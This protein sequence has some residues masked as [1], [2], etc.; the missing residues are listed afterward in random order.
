MSAWLQKFNEWESNVKTSDREKQSISMLSAVCLDQVA[1]VKPR[2]KSTEL[3]PTK[4]QETVVIETTQQFLSFFS[5]IEKE[6]NQGQDAKF[7]DYLESVGEL[8]TLVERLIGEICSA[9]EI[10]EELEHNYEF[11]VKKTSGLQNACESLL[12]EQAHM[13]AISEEISQKLSYFHQLESISKLLNMP[14]DQLVLEPEFGPMLEKLDQCLAFVTDHPTF[15]DS[16]LYR[17]R[18][19]QCMTR[20]MTLIKLHFVDAIRQLQT[21]IRD[22]LK[23]QTGTELISSNVQLSLFFVKFR[24]L[25]SRMRGLVSELEMRC[26]S[27]QEYFAL[28]RDCI[29]AYVKVRR[30][31]LT[32][33]ISE[34]V[35]KKLI[36]SNGVQYA[37]NICTYMLSFCKDEYTLFR[38]FFSL[39][40]T[41]VKNYLESYSSILTYTLRPIILKEHRI[42]ILSD[43]CNQLLFM[44]NSNVNADENLETVEFVIENILQ[45]AQ[46]RLSFRAQDIIQYE[47]RSFKPREAEL[48]ILARGPGLPQPLAV[49]SVVGVADVLESEVLPHRRSSVVL[50]PTIEAAL[51]PKEITH[52]SMENLFGGGEWYPTVQRTVSLLSKLHGCLPQASFDDLAQDA[53]ESCRVSVMAASTMIK[54][55]MS[56]TDS[57]L[58]AIKNLL[59]V[60]EHV[61]LYDSNF[62]RS[63][64]NVQF[65]D[66]MMAVKDVLVRPLVLRNYENLV[67][68]F[69][70]TQE[71]DVRQLLDADLK[72]SCENFVLDQAKLNSEALIH[73]LDT[74]GS[75][76]TQGIDHQYAGRIFLIADAVRNGYQQFL[77]AIQKHFPSTIKMMQNYLGDKSTQLTLIRIIRVTESKRRAPFSHS[78]MTSGKVSK[79]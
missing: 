48:S 54:V 45:D 51:E 59:Q 47:I 9:K 3:T 64:R 24:A 62:T 22:K 35:K 15:K 44:M 78:T 25:A 69:F 38:E 73:F 16:D 72:R 32:P 19:R 8:R 63:T 68:P 66:I 12:D 27:H 79:R 61:S 42:D 76:P 18:Y 13:F 65:S 29:N 70:Q 43:L 50:S 20:S 39:G 75:K 52:H 57:Q 37:V 40:N 4:H 11:V 74:I 23:L 34:N 17:M 60:R 1:Q 36:E 56:T 46:N 2:R 21:E 53:I 58:F 7:N 41:E 31:L 77:S 30:T 33:I 5:E 71:D 10:I 26:P 49:N 6:M 28:L 67:M 55:Q 14:G